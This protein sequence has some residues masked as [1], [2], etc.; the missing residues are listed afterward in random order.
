MHGTTIKDIARNVLF[1]ERTKY[2]LVLLTYK[3]L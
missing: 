3:K 1:T 2:T